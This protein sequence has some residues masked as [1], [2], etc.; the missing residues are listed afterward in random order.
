MMKN[1]LVGMSLLG[2]LGAAGQ[3]SASTFYVRADGGTPA[4]CNGLSDSPYPG[5]GSAQSCAWHHPFDALP[6]QG[7]GGTPAIL[8]QGGDTLII[9]SGSYE[10]GATSP[11]AKGFPACNEGWPW[12]CFMAAIPSG[13]ASQPTQILG[14]GWDSGCK[15]PPELWGS[16]H[17]S[18]VVNL[19]SSSNVKVGCLEITDHS[20]CIESY[21]GGNDPNACNR[22]SAPYGPWA[23]MGV[24][25]KDSSNVTLQDLNIHG[26]ANRGVLAGRLSNWTVSRVKIIGNGWAGWDGDLG[27][28]TLGSSD[29]GTMAFDQLEIGWAG[30]GETYPDKQIYGCWGQQEGGYGDGLGEA[31]TSGNWVI[32]NSYFHHNTQDGLD[33]LYADPTATIKVSQTHAEGNAGNQI[34]LA[35]SPTVE[36]SV[37]D[38][39]CSYFNGKYNMSSGDQCRAQGNALVLSVQPGLKGLARYNTIVSEGDCVVLAINGDTTSSVALQ[40]N[41]LIGKPNFLKQGSQQSCTF[42]WDSGPATWPVTY[43][44]N[45]VYQ[46]KDNYCPPGNNQC[47]V[48]PQLTDESLATFNPQPLSTSPLINAADTTVP[49]VSTD[50]FGNPRPI[51]GGYDVGAV[52]YQ[53]AGSGSTGGSGGGGSTPPTGGTPSAGFTSVTNGLTATFTDTS[54]DTG[55]TISSRSWNF[56]DGA[57][58]TVTNPSHA[59]AAAGTFTVTETV[60]DSVNGKTSTA[61]TSVTVVSP[62]GTP[63]ASFTATTSGL[64]ATFTDASTDSGGTIG[65][66]SWN[67]GDGSTSTATNPSHAYAAAGI[68]TVTETVTDSVS[69]KTSTATNSVTVT[70]PGGTPT[71]SFTATTSAL[72]ATFTDTSTDSGGTIG[73]R[74]WNF[75]D[76]STSTAT[77]PSHA[78]AAAGTYTVTETVTD[79]VS[80]KTSTATNSV[81]VTSPPPQGG[82]P[83]AN[84][85]M[86]TSGLTATFTD[87]STDSGGTIGS[88]KWTFGDGSTSTSTATNPSHTYAAAGT[89]TVTET[90]TDSVSGKTSTATKSVSVTNTALANGHKPPKK[91]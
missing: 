16:E 79:G 71:A 43:T 61:T 86:S 44:G 41:A 5:S 30:C 54:T 26:M 2:A 82:T 8:L 35:G 56:G 72:T 7:D 3:A 64:T 67:F 19:T 11:A 62:G 89:Y 38:G 23:S 39:N 18:K 14:Q 52:E 50:F 90:V 24:Y 42:F 37:I 57:T 70:S 68:Y 55:G 66:R 63:T 29:S 69:G 74:S 48:D 1:L 25:A 88:R 20:S 75:G 22:S 73:S 84:F 34:K 60:T 45:L 4:Q 91:H 17:S 49:T 47:N 77:N 21:M 12:D 28:A 58:S 46:V 85:T 40:N 6:P 36:N 51:S 53:G 81:T 9:D 13:T 15:A 10:M 33:L 59:Y 80:G 65:S 87:S 78:Y 76:G 27:D 31:K 83:T 32:T